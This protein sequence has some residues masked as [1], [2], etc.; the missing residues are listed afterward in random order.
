MIVHAPLPQTH[1]IVAGE[2][3]IHREQKNRQLMVFIVTVNI[4]TIVYIT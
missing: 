2:T 1:S 4:V 3:A